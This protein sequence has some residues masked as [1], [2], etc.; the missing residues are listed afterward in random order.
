MHLLLFFFWQMNRKKEM[1][2]KGLFEEIEIKMDL[3]IYLKCLWNEIFLL[4]YSKYVSKWWRM[5]FI[6]LW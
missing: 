5:A 2:R 3:L 6:L 4:T 1:T